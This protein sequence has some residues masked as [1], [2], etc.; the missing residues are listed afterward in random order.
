MR[1]K[2][3]ARTWAREQRVV[4]VGAGRDACAKAQGGG[5]GEAGG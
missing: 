1:P 3:R 5:Q 4:T 2:R